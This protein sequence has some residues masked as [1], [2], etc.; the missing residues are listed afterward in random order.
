MIQ[1]QYAAKALDLVKD[2]LK[3]SKDKV[4]AILEFIQDN[5]RYVSMS[6]GDHTIDLHSTADIF[7]RTVMGTVKTWR[8]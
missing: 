3:T 7:V 5:F 6:L 4:R 8:C 2:K 1:P